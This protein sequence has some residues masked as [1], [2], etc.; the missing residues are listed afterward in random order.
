MARLVKPTVILQDLVMPGVT[1]S[2][3][4][5]RTA[6]TRRR[7]DIPMIVL[8]SKEDPRIKSEAFARAP[9]TTW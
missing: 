8:S 6:A 3:C 7:T 9:A 1:G 2:S 5:A 4:C